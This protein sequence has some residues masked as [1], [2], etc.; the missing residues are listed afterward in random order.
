MPGMGLRVLL[1]H[2]GLGEGMTAERFWR[3]TGVVAGLEAAGCEVVAPDRPAHPG[4]WREEGDHLAGGLER[5]SAVVGGSNGCSAAVRLAVDHPGLVTR[6]VLAWP[7]TAGDPDLDRHAALLLGDR[8]D[9]LLAGET[10]RG[11]ADAELAAL[12]VPVAVV[13]SEP[14]NRYHQARTVEALR[15]VLAA[16]EVGA[17]HPEPPAP[18]FPPRRG[19]FVAELLRLLGAG[20]PPSGRAG[21]A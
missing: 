1:V 13:P 21:L 20:P 10:L 12:E 5:P 3:R 9:A 11:V 16:P 15:R 6:L 2:G 17:G 18:S 19:A 14:P 8:A 7:A 4:S